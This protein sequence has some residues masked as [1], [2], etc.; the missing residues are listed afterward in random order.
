MSFEVLSCIAAPRVV[1]LDVCACGRIKGLKSFF[2]YDTSLQQHAL[3]LFNPSFAALSTDALPHRPLRWVYQF[4]FI[5]LAFCVILRQGYN[6]D[7]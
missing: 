6:L 5:P 2:E 7:L 4:V 3:Q 1:G